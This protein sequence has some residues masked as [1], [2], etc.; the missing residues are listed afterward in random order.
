MCKKLIYLVSFV[1][2]LSVVLTSA[3]K[4]ELV[5]WWRLDEGSGTIVTDLSEY[6]NDGTLQGDPQWVNGK[7]GKALQ[8][9]GVDEFVEIPHADIL[10]VDNEVT[11][12][13]WIN[14]ERHGGPG[15]ESWQGIVAK[16]N[17]PRSYSL[18]TEASGALH[19]STTSTTINDYVGT[20]ST[21]QVPLNEWVHVAAI[22]VDGGHVYYINGE[23]AGTSGSDIVLPGTDDTSPVVIGRTGEGAARSFLGMIDDVRIYNEA[24][25]QEEIQVIMLGAGMS[26]ASGPSPSDG[27]LHEDTWASL[28]WH[29]GD[30]AASHDVYF[31]ENFVDVNDGAEGTFYGN[32]ADTFFVVGFPGFPYSDGR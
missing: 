9:N 32:Q 8:F 15:T 4:A 25:T 19:F 2:V 5:G 18:Y 26:Y 6:G 3:A 23:P 30:D 10:T 17:S 31:G 21:G 14:A 22:V 13:A 7:F 28:S 11:V 12:M 16:S 1:L 27:V 20:L 29:P 24:L